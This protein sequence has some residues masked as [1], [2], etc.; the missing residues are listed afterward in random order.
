MATRDEIDALTGE[1]A[2]I[3]DRIQVDGDLVDW[4]YVA[5]FIRKLANAIIQEHMA[6]VNEAYRS[7][8]FKPWMRASKQRK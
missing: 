3:A 2:K 8:G 1:A 6:Y 7:Q 5:S 4:K